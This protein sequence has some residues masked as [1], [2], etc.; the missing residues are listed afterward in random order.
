MLGAR[1]GPGLSSLRWRRLGGSRRGGDF[2]SGGT[3]DVTFEM[4]LR[5][6]HFK[7]NIPQRLCFSDL[8][9]FPS[10]VVATFFPLL[11]QLNFEN[12][13]LCILKL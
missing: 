9:L 11:S 7:A 2:V 1:L 8:Y 10:V 5:H 6:P 4:V 3:G 12:Q 13:N